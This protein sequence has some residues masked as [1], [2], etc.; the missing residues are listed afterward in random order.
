VNSEIIVSFD[1]PARM[2]DGTILSANIFRPK[3]KGPFPVTLNRTPYCKDLA[4]SFQ[5]LD[6][7][8]LAQ[9]GYMVVIQDVRGRYK[10]SG[11]WDIFKHEVEDGYDSV[12]W[13]A[14]LPDSNGNVGMWGFSYLGFTQ[15]AAAALQPPHLK[16]IMPALTWSDAR[17][18]MFWRGGALE[19][20]LLGHLLLPSLGA[21]I[22]LKR[23]AG[24]PANDIQA[25]M[26]AFIHELDELPKTGYTSIPLQ[27]FAPLKKFE[28]EMDLLQNLVDHP[29]HA[30]F[31]QSPFSALDWVQ[32][33][34]IPAYNLGG[35]YD[36]FT[37]GTLNNFISQHSQE[38]TAGKVQSH[39]LVGPWA[40]L[41]YGSV[42]GD[43]DFGTIS[44]MAMIDSQYDMV[45]LA[46]HWYDYWLKGIDNGLTEELPV[47]L[48]V[49]GSNTWRNEWEWPLSRAK[50]VSFYL[51]PEHALSVSNPP[52]GDQPDTYIY[53]PANPV[54][55]LGGNILMNPIYGPGVKDQRAIEAR[56][57]VLSYTSAVLEQPLEVIGSLKL[58][59]WAASSACDTDFVA[60]L[61]DVHPDGFAQNLADGIIR[62]RYRNNPDREDFLQPDQPY[63]FELDLWSTANV[64]LPGHKIRL[65]IT[66]SC[67]PR[68][69]RN[70]NTG[71]AFGVSAALCP[72]R[73]II[74]H[75]A[76]HPSC[77]ILPVTDGYN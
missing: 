36:I 51:Q 34:N 58:I 40:H 71:Q 62:A 61:V 33:A 6:I 14:G 53:D 54:P 38:K 49:M 48:F 20:G 56:D 17:E 21:D 39:L 69:D 60:R 65:D 2:R 66:S 29:N 11:Q 70:P 72:A 67:F 63:R 64:F 8:R 4:T 31:S 30:K 68:W 3:G 25:V 26:T 15:W 19:L 24:A 37:Q 22:L 5:Y 57:D 45:G 10:S 28:L 43:H 42:I 73:Q 35:W 13:A 50:K 12:E 16:A 74:F 1:V 27:T 44:Q 76:D 23:M 59:L 77:L 18:G 46:Q 7:V 55:T 9:A 52:V 47:K 75:D 32:K 41:S